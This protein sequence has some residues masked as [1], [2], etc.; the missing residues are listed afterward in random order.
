MLKTAPS[1]SIGSV[2]SNAEWAILTGFASYLG[3]A[4]V[5]AWAIL[6]QIWELFECTIEGLGDAAEIRVSYHLGQFKPYKAKLSAYKSLYLGTIKAVLVGGIMF[7]LLPYIPEFFT[8]DETLQGMIAECLPLTVIGN[9]LMTVGILAWYMVGAQGRYKLGTLVMGVMSWGITLP[10]AAISTYVLH[11]DLQGL[12]TAVVLGYVGVGASLLYIL[13]TSDWIALA[14]KVQKRNAQEEADEQDG[15]AIFAALQARRSRAA[16]AVC[17]NNIKLLTA[18]PGTLGI[19]VGTEQNRVGPVITTV[20]ETSP[21][22]GMVFPGD[23]LIAV[24]GTS[25]MSLS[26]ERI[27]EIIQQNE[28]LDRQISI[29][30]RTPYHYTEDETPEGKAAEPS[31]IPDFEEEETLLP[32]W[33]EDTTDETEAGYVFA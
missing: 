13:L 31:D 1:L 28:H 12:T 24:D 16:R 22:K 29:E 11:V 33:W 27:Y 21:W 5:A 26:I 17:T 4:E 14:E 9:L 25:V 8:V 20:L 7:C 10:L 32:S 23:G 6:G 30:M 15:E 3:P 19:G 18:P 2:L